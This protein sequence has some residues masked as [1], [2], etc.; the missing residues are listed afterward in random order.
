[1][2]ARLLRSEL[3]KL[4]RTPSTW[5]LT[6]A[7]LGIVVLGVVVTL[8]MVDI[9]SRSDLR[10]LLSFSGTGGLILMLFGVVVAAGEYRHRTIV[11][12]LLVTPRRS[13]AFVAQAAGVALFGVA[14]GLVAAALTTAIS[15]TWLA[16]EGVTID[17]TAA[18]LATAWLG[19]TAYTAL[20]AVIGVA[21]GAL[22]RNQVAAA[23]TVFV[24]LSMIDPLV[25]WAWSSYGQFGPTSIGIALAGGGEAV[26]GPGAQL[27]PFWAAALVYL[28]YATVLGTV[29]AV[30]TTRRDIG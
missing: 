8:S 9:S 15:L 20:S 12:T 21:V 13:P 28:G 23:A 11:P 3:L 30:A 26:A 18:D 29:S 1:M 7:A 4:R 10:S 5:W 27:L 24:Y 16:A 22:A 2:S 14:V 25:S 6:G 17:L 19:G